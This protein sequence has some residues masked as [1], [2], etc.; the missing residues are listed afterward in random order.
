MRRKFKRTSAPV[1]GS[2]QPTIVSSTTSQT[3]PTPTM[4]RTSSPKKIIAIVTTSLVLVSGLTL[5]VGVMAAKGKLPPNP[6]TNKLGIITAKVFRLGFTCDVLITD[7]TEVDCG[8]VT[9]PGCEKAGGEVRRC[10]DGVIRCCFGE[11]NTDCYAG[12]VRGCQSKN[13]VVTLPEGTYQVKRCDCPEQTQPTGVC[14]SNCYDDTETGS[15]FKVNS[16]SG[17]H[18]IDVVGFCGSYAFGETGKTGEGCEG[19]ICVPLYPGALD[20][21]SPY[22][23]KPGE[24]IEK[25]SSGL[26]PGSIT[27]LFPKLGQSEN[28]YVKEYSLYARF[29]SQDSINTIKNW[30]L[31]EMEKHCWTRDEGPTTEEITKIVKDLGLPYTAPSESGEH[32]ALYFSKVSKDNQKTTV[33]IGI[34]PV[35]PSVKKYTKEETEQIIDLFPVEGNTW[36]CIIESSPIN[37]EQCTKK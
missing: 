30:Y 19:E 4:G 25:Y 26:P 9:Q 37:L 27:A 11:S 28:Y 8:G 2:E 17:G 22:F 6:I 21:R 16:G 15:F 24:T 34:Y 7:C 3:L 14:S 12:L 32:A 10:T 29:A 35:D 18:Q 31:A 20:Y 13:G 23:W 1:T 33:S 36:V 5:V